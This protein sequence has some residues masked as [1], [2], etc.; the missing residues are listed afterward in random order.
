MNLQELLLTMAVEL[1]PQD[2]TEVLDGIGRF[3]RQ[4][5]GADDS[6]ILLLKARGKV[7]TPVSTSENVNKAHALQAELDEGPCL[8]VIRDTTAVLYTGDVAHEPR[9]PSWGARCDELGYRSAMSVRLAVGE[10]H[11]GSLNV[12]SAERDAF[13][14]NDADVLSVLGAHASVALAAAQDRTNLVRALDNRTSIGQAQGILMAVFD[15]DA[16]AAF[17]YLSRMSQDRNVKLA[18]VAHEIVEQ[19]GV[20]RTQT[21]H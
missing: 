14:G 7:E 16:D 8:D 18:D 9:W 2:D 12:Y 6:G 10:R 5:L 4:A 17:G 3:A 20:I 15:I 21:V 1:S 19:R 11:Q 13:D